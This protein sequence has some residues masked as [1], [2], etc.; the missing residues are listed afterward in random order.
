MDVY[1]GSS[2]IVDVTPNDGAHTYV[3]GGKGAGSF[4]FKVCQT[5]STTVCSNTSTVNF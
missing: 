1:L 2:M 4:T 5:G 3:I